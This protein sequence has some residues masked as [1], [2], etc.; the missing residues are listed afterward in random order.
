MAEKGKS[1]SLWRTLGWVAYLGL[2]IAAGVTAISEI[3]PELSVRQWWENGAQLPIPTKDHA[4]RFF[5]DDLV[6]RLFSWLGDWLGPPMVRLW[7]AIFIH[8]FVRY[9]VLAVL[10]VFVAEAAKDI[11]NYAIRGGRPKS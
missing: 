2:L 7:N 11:Y 9:V 1:K 4:T 8:D 10:A 6:G 5:A 3:P